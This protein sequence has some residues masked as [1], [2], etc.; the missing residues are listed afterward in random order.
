MRDLWDLC[1]VTDLAERERLMIL[2]RKGKQRARWQDYDLPYATYVGL[3][4][5][6]AS[7]SKNDPGSSRRAAPG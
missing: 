4:A 1:Q 2:A 3:E 5:E 6:A 7:I